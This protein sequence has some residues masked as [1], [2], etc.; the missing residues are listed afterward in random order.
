MRIT[1]PSRA[2]TAALKLAPVHPFS[3]RMAPRIALR[4]LVGRERCTVLDPM[5][6]SGT[7]LAVAHA[8]GH[9]AVGYDVDPLAVLLARTWCTDVDPAVVRRAAHGVMGRATR[10]LR[11]LTV[12]AAYPR[13]S[14]PATCKY[15]R[16]WFDPKARRQLAALSRAIQGVRR[17]DVRTVLWC[18]FSRLIITKDAG[19]SLA[20]DVS[21]GRPHRSFERCPRL[22]LKNFESAVEWILSRA[23]SRR[24][25]A[26]AKVRVDL[27]DARKLV[28]KARSVDV[29]VTSPPYLNALDY[30]RGHRLSLVWMGWTLSQLREIRSQSTGSEAGLSAASI[31]DAPLKVMRA[32]RVE[33]LDSRHQG[34]LQR[35][36]SDLDGIAAEVARVLRPDGRAVFVVGDSTLRGVPIRNSTALR[37]VA[38]A[39]GLR[40]IRRHTRAL[41]ENRRY[42][43][44]PKAGRQGGQLDKRMRRE[45][46]MEFAHAA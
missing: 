10:G 9:R 32:L 13:G 7:T 6:G 1:H 24:P 45:V 41:P 27:G 25:A 5:A 11:T 18:A 46:V 12:G 19:A 34:M 4:A 17:E 31:S 21:H 44:P 28:L 16:Y 33:E 35:Y 3:A 2:A 38:R 30:M 20:R 36:I 14:D 42:L 22:P 15:I 37:M 26:R 39:N 43:P 23:P 29:V 8:L 40:L